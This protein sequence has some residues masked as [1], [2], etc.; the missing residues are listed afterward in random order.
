MMGSSGSLRFT[1]NAKWNKNHCYT[2]VVLAQI[3]KLELMPGIVE[4]WGFKEPHALLM[5]MWTAGIEWHG[6]KANVLF[7][8]IMDLQML[9]PALQLQTPGVF[10]EGYLG[11]CPRE[12]LT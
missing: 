6:W 10:G 3:T 9:W 12:S 8:Q 2:C 4:R 1:K 7:G 11:A 5:S